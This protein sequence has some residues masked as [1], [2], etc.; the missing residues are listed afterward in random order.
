M[1]E[2]IVA[3]VKHKQWKESELKHVKD[4]RATVGTLKEALNDLDDNLLLSDR[5]EKLLKRNYF[6]TSNY[7]WVQEYK[8]ALDNDADKK[9]EEPVEKIS[10]SE[11]E[12][13]DV[14]VLEN[15]SENSSE[16]VSEEPDVAEGILEVCSKNILQC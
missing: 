2:K 4:C 13:M 16:D 9:V 6:G 7:R 15:V 12:N 14:E 3:Y 1:S 11:T 8:K 5:Q 10:E